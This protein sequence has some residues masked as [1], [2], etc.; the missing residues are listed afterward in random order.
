MY[1]AQCDKVGPGLTN[2]YVKYDKV[3]PGLTIKQCTL[4]SKVLGSIYVLS[5]YFPGKSLQIKGFPARDWTGKISKE[6]CLQT[7][8]IR[9]NLI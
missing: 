8:V 9:F 5:V 4:Y 2:K 6:K 1:I 3:G 7:K